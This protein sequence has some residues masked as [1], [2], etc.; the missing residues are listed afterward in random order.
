MPD[1]AK[2]KTHSTTQQKHE[3]KQ[4]MGDIHLHFPTHARLQTYSE[5]NVKIAFRSRN[6]IGSLIKPSKDHNIPPHNWE[7]I[8]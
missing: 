2:D 8:N 3:Q 1:K 5:T 6:T 4:T 7:F